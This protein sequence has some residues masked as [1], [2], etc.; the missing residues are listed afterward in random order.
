MWFILFFLPRW[1]SL[2]FPA[3]SD[4]Q[5]SRLPS[6]FLACA[7]GSLTPPIPSAFL[8]SHNHLASSHS[9]WYQA[10]SWPSEKEAVVTWKRFSSL[11]KFWKPDSV[12]VRLNST[13]QTRGSATSP[14]AFFNCKTRSAGESP[15]NCTTVPA[16][17]SQLWP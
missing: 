6:H 8:I 17:P 7:T 12:S 1:H 14:P 11:K 5:S 9:Y 3:D 4:P 2:L 13:S 10:L 15:A 16:S